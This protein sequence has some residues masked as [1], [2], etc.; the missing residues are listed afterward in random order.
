MVTTVGT[1]GDLK[2]L[3]E[4]YI[5]LE[6]DAISAYEASIERLED[7]AHKA[8]IAEFKADHERHLRELTELATAHDAPVPAEGDMKEMLTTGKIK[9]ADMMGQDGAILKA[10]ST[11]ETDTVTAYDRAVQNEAIPTAARPIFARAL[12]DERRHKA[13]MENAAEAA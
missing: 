12:E 10:M 2:T 6:R 7:P 9:I 5:A 1:S 8:K 4:D 3:L 13:Y 11:N